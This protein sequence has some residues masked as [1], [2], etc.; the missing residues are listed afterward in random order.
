M[1][2]LTSADRRGSFVT[3]CGVSRVSPRPAASCAQI[4]AQ[5]R[6]LSC[7][8]PVAPSPR[9]RTAFPTGLPWAN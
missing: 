1:A 5:I 6:S 7:G 4:R 2:A 8:L 3:A 9:A